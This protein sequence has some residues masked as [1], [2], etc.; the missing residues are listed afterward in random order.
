VFVYIVLV[1]YAGTGSEVI[2]YA[3]LDKE[4]IRTYVL[5]FIETIQQ[6][7]ELYFAS[8]RV[9]QYKLETF[10]FP[11]PLFIWVAGMPPVTNFFEEIS[12]TQQETEVKG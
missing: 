9:L 7:S 6:E 1:D 2:S 12:T 3:S 10:T 5:N 4:Q 11:K 8:V